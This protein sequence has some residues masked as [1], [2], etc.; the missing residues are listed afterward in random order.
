MLSVFEYSCKFLDKYVEQ[1][2]SRPNI[3][4]QPLIIFI[5]G[6]QGSGKSYNGQKIHDYLSEKYRG[7]K[8]VA[9]CSIDDFYL[10]HEDQQALAQQY[11]DNALLQ[12]RGLPGTHDLTLL[13][14][15][16]SSIL[17]GPTDEQRTVALPRYDKSLFSGEGDRSTDLQ[18]VG[19]PV[20]IF[21]VEGWF[22]GYQPLLQTADT[23]LIEGDMADINA[24]L[25]MYSDL[26]WRNPEVHSLGIVI[27]T[28]DIH[29]VYSWRTEQEHE[30]KRLKGAGMSDEAVV[31]FVDRYMPC[32]DLYFDDFVHSE[33]LGSV[34]TLTIGIDKSRNVY[35]IKTKA[36]E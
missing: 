14:E 12:G 33:N 1:W 36:I 30:T 35:S 20:D 11:R 28:D 13:N 6:P 34:A 19:L 5:S 31:K 32:Y 21:I 3:T 23:E 24:K 29:N 16:L 8:I 9:Y 2:F 27:G 7:D 26:L 22:L 4:T 15:C 18:E 10:T 25:F 17:K